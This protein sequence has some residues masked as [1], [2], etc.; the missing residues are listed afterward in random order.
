[1]RCNQKGC[2]FDWNDPDSV[3]EHCPVCGNPMIYEPVSV[4]ELPE[5]HDV[6][7]FETVLAKCACTVE[8]GNAK[9][10]CNAC[11]GA[12]AVA[13]FFADGRYYFDE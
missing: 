10:N 4:P 5:K 1:M 7:D 12:G 13:V 2:E 6:G 9:A 11:H 3:P 8:D